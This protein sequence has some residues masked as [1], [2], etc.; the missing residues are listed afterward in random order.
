LNTDA[1]EPRSTAFSVRAIDSERL[2]GLS[3]A[4]RTLTRGPTMHRNFRLSLIAS[5]IIIITASM[6]TG[7]ADAGTPWSC[8]CDGKLRRV[9]AGTFACEFDLNKD[10]GRRVRIGNRLLVPHCTSTQFRAWNR[11]ACAEDGCTL[12]TR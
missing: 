11:R 9:I 3:D 2:S 7:T 4:I 10:N 12:P 1:V 5:S 8:I 6:L